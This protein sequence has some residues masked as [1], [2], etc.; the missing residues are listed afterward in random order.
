MLGSTVI[1]QRNGVGLTASSDSISTIAEATDLQVNFHAMVG[2]HSHQVLG[3][4]T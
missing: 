4:F 2:R 1:Q 3:Q